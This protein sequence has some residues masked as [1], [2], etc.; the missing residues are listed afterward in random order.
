M[1]ALQ[2]VAAALGRSIGGVQIRVDP[3]ASTASTNGKTVILPVLPAIASSQEQQDVTLGLVCHEAFHIRYTF[4]GKPRDHK[5]AQIA[6]TPFKKRLENA[7]EDARIE[8]LGFARYPGTR[9]FLDRVVEHLKR[10]RGFPAYPSVQEHPGNL[11]I[12]GLLYHYRANFLGQDLALAATNWKAAV[13][14]IFGSDLWNRAVSI[15][16]AAVRA[17]DVDAPDGPWWAAEKISALLGSA[18]DLP[19]EAKKAALKAASADEG[20]LRSADLAESTSIPKSSSTTEKE[21]PRLICHE[22]I[23]NPQ[24]DAAKQEANRIYRTICGPLEAKLWARSQGE[25]W[26]SRTGT[27]GVVPTAIYQAGTTGRVFRSRVEGDTRSI[28]VHLLVD[29]SS[30]MSYEAGSTHPPRHWANAG[31]LAL[32]RLFTSIGIQWGMSWFNDTW[33]QGRNYSNAPVHRNEPWHWDCN[34]GTHLAPAMSHA[35]VTLL[36]VEAD[37]KLLLVL[38]DGAANEQETSTVDA[39]LLRQ[40]I[41]TRYALIGRLGGFDFAGDRVASGEAD[42]TAKT[43]IAAFR[44]FV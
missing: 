18:A 38:T 29:V 1:K 37:R 22:S 27:C 39:E 7:L 3:K 28:A 14:R 21:M 36:D 5:P 12:F 31:A 17:S 10:N 43:L 33:I 6:Y 42:D 40:G 2:I 44:S 13:V 15:A 11:V 24:L 32:T 25:E 34:G 23:A 26:V 8:N 41:E 19:E 9:K 4:W 35:G 20:D 30:S 16:D